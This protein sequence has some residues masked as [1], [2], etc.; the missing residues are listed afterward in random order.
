ME[1]V[2]LQ[3]QKNEITEFKIYSKLASKIKDKKNKTLLKK[4]AQDELKH[5]TYWKK[6]TKRDVK[7]NCLR[8]YWYHLLST[9]LGLS[10][11]L[12]F[13]EQ[14]E[15]LAIKLYNK[16]KD[17]YKINTFIRD[18]Q[19]HEEQLL[20]L[21]KEER[22]KY[23][24]SIVL[25]LNDALVE[26][27]G[28]LAGFTFAL[29]NSR[30]IAIAGSITG[31]AASLSMAASGYLSSKEEETDEKSPL[32]SAIYTGLAYIF[33]VIILILPYLILDSVYLALIITLSLAILIIAAYTFYITTA[34]NLNF[35]KRFREMALISLTVAIISFGI[36]Y[37]IRI[38][39][40]IEV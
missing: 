30:L 4:I 38:Y 29:Q 5:Y 3:A 17:K 12:K 35:W 26:L 15:N 23:A 2:I 8:V 20:S 27:T 11:T 18:E 22:I 19:R 31:I 21:I 9:F 40:G 33:T 25:G 1:P 39:F 24:G 37:L 16:L 14:G 36:G 10:F 32:K 13:M 6:I 34:K 28:A 7:P